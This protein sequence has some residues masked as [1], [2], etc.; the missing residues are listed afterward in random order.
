MTK[1]AGIPFR[2]GIPESRAEAQRFRVRPSCQ[3]A[4]R[5]RSSRLMGAHRRNFPAQRVRS[6]G[7]KHAHP[8]AI[9]APASFVVIPLLMLL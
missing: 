5:R 4:E 9:S 6:R 2:T 8:I 1:S 3:T 7:Q